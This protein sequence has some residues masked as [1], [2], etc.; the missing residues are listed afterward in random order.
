MLTSG[1][2][3]MKNRIYLIGLFMLFN[4][5]I[6]R[7]ADFREN[8][9]TFLAIIMVVMVVLLM[10]EDGI[11]ANLFKMTDRVVNSILSK[12]DSISKGSE[13]ESANPVWPTSFIWFTTGFILGFLSLNFLPVSPVI[14]LYLRV[15]DLLLAPIAVA[16][17]S[18]MVANYWAT[19][20]PS[21]IPRNIFWQAFWG[22]LGFVLVRFAFAT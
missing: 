10:F 2:Q 18:K 12:L 14:P 19:K 1:V 13:K 20:K 11:G 17:I 3:K 4:S 22:S 7:A 8:F 21:L 16:L 6:A 9:F 15:V 5:P